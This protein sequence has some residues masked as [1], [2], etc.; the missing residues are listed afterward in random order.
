MNSEPQSVMEDDF[1][2]KLSDKLGQKWPEIAKARQAAEDTREKIAAV[3]SS[4]GKLTSSDEDIVAFGS[5]AR[6][7]WTSKSDVDWTLLIDGQ[8]KPEHRT[9]AQHVGRQLEAEGF[10]APGTTGT[11]GNLAFSHDIVHLIGGQDDTNVNTT[12]RILL[13]LESTRIASEPSA[14][15]PCA[16]D[17]V[18]RS[19]LHR[20]L[21]DDTNLVSNDGSK[22]NVP[23]FLLNDIVRFWRTM[24]VDFAWK[25]WEQ[26]QMKWAL[27]NIKLRMS[28]KLIFASGL[29]MCA[30]RNLN[31]ES[32][33]DSSTEVSPTEQLLA[34]LIRDVRM[35]PLQ[36]VARALL[37]YGKEDTGKC[38]MGS[39]DWF[40]GLLNDEEKRKHLSSLSATE[41][42]E[43]DVFN[44]C[45]TK[46]HE[47][48]SGLTDLFF[49][50]HKELSEFTKMY[51][52]F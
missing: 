52:V 19:V 6:D 50:D 9:I 10:L 40:L 7:E 39:H 44:E 24:C 23:R 32:E 22:S 8:A 14:N 51:G 16:Y 15:G 34:L 18:I 35:T 5:L 17:R 1:V 21:L 3:L 20:Y 31:R 27:R 47:F 33:I 11:F 4:K 29:L 48:Q 43:D 36:I 37:K 26:A 38:I 13:L 12:Q 25:G 41:A 42:Y 49:S 2:S 28:R 30:E 46:S 45:R